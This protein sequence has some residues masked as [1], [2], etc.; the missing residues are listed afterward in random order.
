MIPRA[1]QAMMDFHDGAWN[2]EAIS[3]YRIDLCKKIIHANRLKNQEQHH[4]I[5]GERL[6]YCVP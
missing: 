5:V 2:S 3:F 6:N 1:M 4:F